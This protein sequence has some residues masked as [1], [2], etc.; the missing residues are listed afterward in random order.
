MTIIHIETSTNVCSVAASHNGKCIF[1]T[2]NRDGLNHAAM[3]SPF[4]QQALD[5][6]NELNLKPMPLQ[7]AAALDHI[8]A[9]G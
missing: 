2:A 1:E 4:V 8:Q 9:C 6:L 5:K 7:S 3:L